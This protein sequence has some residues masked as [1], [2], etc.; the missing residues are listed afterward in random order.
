MSKRL[1]GKAKVLANYIKGDKI[2]DLGSEDGTGENVLHLYMEKHSKKN[3]LSVDYVGKPD[4]KADLTKKFPF[5]EGEF[6]TIIAS[7]IIEHIDNP[8]DFLKE[9]KRCVKKG[10]NILLTTPNAV[11]IAEMQGLFKKGKE[12]TYEEHM[13]NWNKK[14]MFY[15][16][17]RAG[18]KIKHFEY[19]SF[20]WRRNL[21]FRAF[22][23]MVP[24]LKP[25]LFFVFTK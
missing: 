7:E 12:L 17:K 25:N 10:G 2:A 3:I 21:F 19:I 9:C 18:L 22:V 6:D 16:S 23:S 15:L 14:N 24:F 11:S 4:L 13:Y 20:Y 5:K 8:L 1:E